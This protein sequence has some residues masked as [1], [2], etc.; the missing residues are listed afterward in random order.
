MV[1]ACSQSRNIV[2]HVLPFFNWVLIAR[3]LVVHIFP[4]LLFFLVKLAL[5][6]SIVRGRVLSCIHLNCFNIHLYL[7]SKSLFNSFVVPVFLAKLRSKSSVRWLFMFLD[8]NDFVGTITKVNSN[9]DEFI[10]VL[11]TVFHLNKFEF[12]LN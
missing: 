8:N 1:I 10:C 4:M 12:K 2:A 9:L 3:Y 5:I 6:I 11:R 7:L